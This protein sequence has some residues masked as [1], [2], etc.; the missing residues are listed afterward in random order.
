MNTI[1]ELISPLSLLVSLAMAFVAWKRLYN[2]L[3]APGIKLTYLSLLT[4]V[5]LM[6]VAIVVQS[7]FGAIFG[8]TGLM[9]L[10]FVIQ[11]AKAILMITGAYGLLQLSKHFM[12][13]NV[14]KT[15]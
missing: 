6:V 2:H 15:L 4:F 1:I 9:Y 7:V 3:N 13:E 14:N 8:L 11:L 5:I 12:S 10:I